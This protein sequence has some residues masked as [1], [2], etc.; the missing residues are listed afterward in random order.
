M[1]NTTLRLKSPHVVLTSTRDAMAALDKIQ[2]DLRFS[3]NAQQRMENE[4]GIPLTP[5]QK[6]NIITYFNIAGNEQEN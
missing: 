6:R 5:A 3:G 2:A 4:G 1:K